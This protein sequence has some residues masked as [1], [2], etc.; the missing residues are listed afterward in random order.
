MEKVIVMIDA[1]KEKVG[2][3]K[4]WRLSLSGRG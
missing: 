2:I 1:I 3:E 4:D